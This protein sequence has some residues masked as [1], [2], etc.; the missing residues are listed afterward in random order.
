MAIWACFNCEGDSVYDYETKKFTC[1]YCGYEFQVTKKKDICPWC[2]DEY[3]SYTWFDP[4]SCLR[5][6]RSFI[7]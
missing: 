2:G 7:E 1:K 5:C 4:S 6:R 3:D